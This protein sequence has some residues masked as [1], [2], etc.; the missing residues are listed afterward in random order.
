[1]IFYQLVSPDV[2]EDETHF[3]IENDIKAQV[4]DLSSVKNPDEGLRSILS[5]ANL[6]AFGLSVTPSRKIAKN[7]DFFEILTLGGFREFATVSDFGKVTVI[8]HRSSEYQYGEWLYG[9]Q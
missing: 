4:V 2:F 3:N 8:C 5:T 6:E 9:V 7:D 1:M